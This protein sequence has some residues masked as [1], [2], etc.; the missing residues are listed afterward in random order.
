MIRCN[1]QIHANEVVGGMLIVHACYQVIN[2]VMYCSL[3]I[4]PNCFCSILILNN[5]SETKQVKKALFC[6]ARDT[7]E[8][9]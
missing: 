6:K 1:P 8:F 5:M 2:Q 9:H 4:K 7:K 3:N